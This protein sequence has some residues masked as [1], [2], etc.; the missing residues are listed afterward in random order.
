MARTAYLDFA[1]FRFGLLLPKARSNASGFSSAPTSAVMATNRSCCFAGVR[2]IV[3]GV[4]TYGEQQR[5]KACIEGADH[6]Q[7]AIEA[8]RQR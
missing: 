7:R 2:R 5:E 6:L 8:L 1:G 3:C 4:D